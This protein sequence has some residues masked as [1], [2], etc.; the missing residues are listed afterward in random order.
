[1]DF[2]SHSPS[3]ISDP[4][5]LI[6]R[7]HPVSID[8]GTD[9]TRNKNFVAAPNERDS[10]PTQIGAGDYT[11]GGA[12]FTSCYVLLKYDT[13]RNLSAHHIQNGAEHLIERGETEEEDDKHLCCQEDHV[14]MV[15]RQFD[16]SYRGIAEDLIYMY[17]KGHVC[18]IDGFENFFVAGN[19]RIQFCL[20]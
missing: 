14:V 18:L 20:S 3:V 12:Y 16:E 1:M 10:E 13:E 4:P 15:A 8:K 2:I 9:V 7:K 11:I 17:G 19:L 6:A 5:K